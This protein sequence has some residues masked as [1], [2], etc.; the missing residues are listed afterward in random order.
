MIVIIG[1]SK[2]IGKYLF[3]S[4]NE[5]GE[6]LVGTYN[7]SDKLGDHYYKVDITQPVQVDFFVSE[8]ESQLIN[9]DL[10]N[11]A[12]V[13]YNCFAHKSDRDKWK[14]IA[15]VN[16]IGTFNIIRS[17]LP[18]MREQQY[19]RI[20]NISSVVAQ[21]GVPGTSA[22]AASKAGLW[23]LAKSL[24]QEN[25]H[26]NITINNINLGYSE[27]GMIRD[28]P[29]AYLETI[30]QQIPAKK[31]CPQNDILLTV[32]YLRDCSYINGASIDLNGGLI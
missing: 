14:Y 27:L 8:I 18:Y 26:L 6:E 30:M 2:G 19:G 24:V 28:V 5:I 21:K 16:L 25:A 3:D 12:G 20:I 15:E 7:T 31:L 11:C 22:Y 1:A 9:V 29:D 17:L 23:G 32:N 4:Y 13:S 10:I